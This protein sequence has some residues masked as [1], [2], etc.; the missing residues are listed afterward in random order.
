MTGSYDRG[1]LVFDRVVP[2]AS[3]RAGESSPSARPATAFVTHRIASRARVRGRA[4][5]TTKGDANR[6]ADAW[7]ER[8]GRRPPGARSPS[9]FPTR[10]RHRDAQRAQGPHD[11][12]RFP[13]CS[14]PSPP[15]PGLARQHTGAAA[16]ASGMIRVLHCWRRLAGRLAVQ[17]RGHVRGATPDEPGRVV[18]DRCQVR[19][20]VTLTAPPT[21]AATNDRRRR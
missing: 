14:S 6:A 19:A 18:H 15:W 13:A 2:I 9:T 3:L 8:A 4:C 10:L 20:V 17:G 11:R 7:G 1:S 12:H 16:H 5:F 21:A